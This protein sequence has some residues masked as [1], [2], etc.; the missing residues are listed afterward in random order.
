M[1]NITQ[2]ELQ[3]LRLLW[4]QKWLLRSSL[5]PWQQR[6]GDGLADVELV[7]RG[8]EGLIYVHEPERAVRADAALVAQVRA[9]F[10]EFFS[11]RPVLDS[12]S[13]LRLVPLSREV[14]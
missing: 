2:A 5:E 9:A 11:P 8:E 3:L 1:K 14:G 4:R 10:P 7:G 12:R 13:A 6:V